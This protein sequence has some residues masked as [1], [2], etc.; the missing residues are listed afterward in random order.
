MRVSPD[1]RLERGFPTNQPLYYPNHSVAKT[2]AISA[3][4]NPSANAG[5]IANRACRHYK[6]LL[7]LLVL[8]DDHALTDLHHSRRDLNTSQRPDA[9]SNY[10]Q[11]DQEGNQDPGDDRSSQ[12]LNSLKKRTSSGDSR[13]PVG[14]RTGGGWT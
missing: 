2:T 9:E 13:I 10:R 14:L 5:A 1:C 4:G 7:I 6:R 8:S 11:E 3:T 12:D